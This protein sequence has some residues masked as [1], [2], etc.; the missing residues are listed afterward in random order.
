MNS[1]KKEKCRAALLRV[2]GKK[3][4]MMSYVHKRIVAR[5]KNPKRSPSR[6]AFISELY[7]QELGRHWQP[8]GLTK[9]DRLEVTRRHSPEWR[10]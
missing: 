2:P 6:H 8:R 1:A 3:A 7:R 4:I 10:S 9:N 5:K